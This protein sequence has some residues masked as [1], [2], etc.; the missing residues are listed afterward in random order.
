MN[1]IVPPQSRR[2]A[3]GR[4]LIRGSTKR[5]DNGTVFLRFF[6][7]RPLLSVAVVAV[8]SWLVLSNDSYVYGPDLSPLYISSKEQTPAQN[9]SGLINNFIE[10]VSCSERLAGRSG[11]AQDPNQGYTV[12][13]LPKKYVNETDPKFWISLHKE[14][15]DQLRWVHIYKNGNYYETGITDQF[16]EIL[17]SRDKKGLVIDVGM[18]IGWFTVYSRA[19]GHD[20]VG[21]DPYPIM[22]TRVCESLDLNGWL[23]DNSVK[24]FIQ[25]LG[26]KTETLN[27]T[28]GK[29]PGGT[30]FDEDRLAKRFRKKLEVSVVRLDDVAE[31]QGWI[32]NEEPIYILKMDVEG[33]EYYVL[34]GASKLL[35]SRKIENLILE[36]SNKDLRQVIDMYAAIY[37]AGYEVHMLSDVQGNP[38]HEEMIPGMNKELQGLSPGAELSQAGENIKFLAEV[39]CNLWWKRRNESQN[40]QRNID[41]GSK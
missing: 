4:L 29:N 23:N 41:E 22:H 39:S 37:D 14:Y 28:T 26:E 31:Q 38:Y 35:Q 15:F 9:N 7:T 34:G 32:T 21:F 20:V 17:H 30:S 1:T 25:G 33:Y 27:I 40:F 5:E 8:S 6:V 36:N 18:N 11:D 13:K 19:M 2:R 3:Q 24:T 12:D 16:K 10:P